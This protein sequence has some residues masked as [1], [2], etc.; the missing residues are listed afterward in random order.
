MSSSHETLTMNNKY[1]NATVFFLIG[2]VFGGLFVAYNYSSEEERLTNQAS[3]FLINTLDTKTERINEYFTKMEKDILILSGSEPVKKMLN[4]KLGFDE[5]V[6]KMDVDQRARIIAKEIENYIKF[7][8]NMTLKDLQ[9][10]TEFQQNAIQPVGKD[11]YSVIADYEKQIIVMHKFDEFVG[12][13]FEG[14]KGELPEIYEMQ[15]RSKHN[16]DVSGFYDW[17]DSNGSVRRK[18]ARMLRIEPRTADGVG[19]MAVTTVY[20]DDYKIVKDITSDQDTY[21]KEFDYENVI[22]ISPEGQVIHMNSSK[23]GQGTNLLWQIN[24][25]EWLSKNYIVTKESKEISFYG[26]FFETYGA[27]YPE[28]SV[29]VPVYIGSELLGYVAITDEM[30]EIF[31]IAKENVEDSESYLINTEGL[32][33]SPLKN[34]SYDI[35]LQSVDSENSEEC[36]EDYED[37][38]DPELKEIKE[39]KKD[40]LEFI[41]YRGE[42]AIGTH[43]YIRKIDWCFLM[44]SSKE[45]SIDKPLKE[46]VKRKLFVYIPT[47]FILSLFGFFIGMYLDKID[48]RVKVKKY[49]CGRVAKFRPWY[50]VIIGGKCNNSFRGT[51]GTIIK[52]KNFLRDIKMIYVILFSFAVTLGYLL[53]IPVLFLGEIRF[54]HFLYLLPEHIIFFT[55]LVL[56]FYGNKIKYSPY[57]KFLF[58]GSATII[59]NYLLYLPL[60]LYWIYMGPFPASIWML[61]PILEFSAMF[62]LFIYIGDRKK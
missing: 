41:D 59:L 50:C 8:P 37:H 9:E 49:P 61:M 22:L 29:V 38:Y 46:S 39:H 48:S 25:E 7:H 56:L 53:L 14:T 27:I 55:S 23:V 3:D 26:P 31:E 13:D 35:M 20:V 47:I 52:T 24:L 57:R 40:I 10:N 11:S 44:E 4:S 45:E 54:Q 32:L 12:N 43:N 33:I 15:M 2:I 5:E 30:K 21:L 1:K 51:C 58:F 36:L 6:I 34:Q 42:N 62:F 17:K 18:Y 28:I 16:S 60:Q 19:L